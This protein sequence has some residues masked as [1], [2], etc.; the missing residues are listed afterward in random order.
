MGVLEID[1]VKNY[2]LAFQSQL[3][4]SL[5]EMFWSFFRWMANSSVNLSYSI[6][7]DNLIIILLSIGVIQT[8]K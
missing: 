7:T 5:D 4:F 1:R 8:C 6:S 3:G 2:Q